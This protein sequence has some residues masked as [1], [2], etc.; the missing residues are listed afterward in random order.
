[1]CEGIKYNEKGRGGEGRKEES[2]H[3]DYQIRCGEHGGSLT[4]TLEHWNT[5]TP[6]HRP[7][8]PSRMI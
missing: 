4:G 6:E 1:L 5:G 7:L 2:I 3:F 8:K